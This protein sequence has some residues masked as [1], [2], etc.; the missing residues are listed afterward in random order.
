MVNAYAISGKEGLFYSGDW[1]MFQT[2]LLGFLVVTVW[3]CMNMIPFF[4]LL[5]VR[6]AGRCWSVPSW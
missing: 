4:A 2:Q 5:K 3:V 6:S 1:T